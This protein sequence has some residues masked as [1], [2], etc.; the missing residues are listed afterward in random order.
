MRISRKKAAVALAAV[1][2]LGLSACG[3]GGDSGGSESEPEL[4]NAGLGKIVDESDEKGGTLKFGLAGEWGDTVDPGETYYG[5]SWDMLRNYGRSLVMFKTEPGKAGLELTPD[6][7]T[8]LGKSSDGGK[9]WTYT[10]QDGLKFE[11]GSPIT[12]QDVKY[13]V[14]RSTDKKT[15]PNG[16]AY[17]EAMLDLPKGWDGPYR[18]KNMNTDSA[19]ETPD[20]KTIV[21][22][23][24]QP[25]AG[26]DYLAQL[27]Q[28]VPVPQEKDTGAKYKNHPISSGPYMFKGNYNPTTGFTLVRNPNWDPET[29]PNR[30]ALP[31]EMTVKVNMSP[32]DV[33]NQIIAGTLD[34][35]IAG[36][37]VQPASVPKVLQQADLRERA[38]N[39]VNARLWYTSINPTVKP[40]DNIECRKA[41]MYGMSP[42]SYQNAYGG[43]YAGGDIATTIMPPMIPGYQDFDLWGQK[44]NPNGQTDKAKDAL[45]KCG[46]PDGFEINMGYRDDRPKEK[47]TAEAFQQALEKVGITVTPKALPSGDYFS[48][49]CGLPS[50]V[51]K[52][53]IGLCANGW[54][55]DWP[56]GYGFLS[57]IVD[58]RV[59]RET[60]GSSNTSVRIPEV[61]KML[62]DA[63]VEQDETKRN[64]MW[65]EIDKR[66]MEEAVIYPGVYA[67]AVLLRSKN[68]TN[69]FVNESF[70]Y[71]DYTAMGVKQ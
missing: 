32:D 10:L 17:F 23:L 55:A 71:Y 22:H 33:D 4:S 65:G 31:D 13:A 52:N 41:I 36:T 12:S 14:L 1:A 28:T 29:D 42:T 25:F 57:Q 59:I 38:D 44:D 19:I 60:G 27:P 37:G 43:K 21:F 49:T 11:D 24:K 66:V 3:S 56:D 70:G 53:N 16:P 67:K 45:E 61:D 48:T 69:V 9:T 6:L 50:Y 20:D 7:A 47:A 30:K 39:P 46:Q 34:V 2:A 68:T 40:L 18:T 26:F 8:D 64:E 54:G 51:V 63:I 58:S 62:D 5:Y 15:F 35:D